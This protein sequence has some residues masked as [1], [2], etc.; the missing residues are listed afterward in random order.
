MNTQSHF[1]RS[2]LIVAL[3]CM[4]VGCRSGLKHISKNPG[5]VCRVHETVYDH[6]VRS[7][8]IITVQEDGGYTW[9]EY[10]FGK[11]FSH[12]RASLRTTHYGKIGES[13]LEE[14]KELLS[15]KA[16]WSAED[17][18]PTIYVNLDFKNPYPECIIRLERVVR[19]EAYG[20]RDWQ[21][22]KG[23]IPVRWVPIA[24]STMRDMFG[25]V[26][27]LEAIPPEIAK[28]E[29]Y[30]KHI[31]PLFESKKLVL[32]QLSEGRVAAVEIR[33]SGSSDVNLYWKIYNR[34]GV[35][36]RTG[37]YQSK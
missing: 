19:S 21:D 22:S 13:L 11:H 18:L 37:H 35:V 16:L 20:H 29:D 2:V 24:E 32:Y 30:R 3:G 10:R 26:A 6:G 34:Q 33:P 7:A 15:S 28:F 8:N 27:R 31:H 1:L 5:D 36:E 12:R 23:S 14:L 25:E 4:L 17:G 9:L